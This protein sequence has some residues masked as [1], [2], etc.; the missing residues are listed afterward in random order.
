VVE[1]GASGAAC[2]CGRSDSDRDPGTIR[3]AHLVLDRAGF[4]PQAHLT[5][6]STD[7]THRRELENKSLDD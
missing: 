5:V 1:I 7:V 6:E 2:C 3:A 4:G